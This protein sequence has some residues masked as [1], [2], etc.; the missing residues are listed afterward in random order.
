MS[1]KIS[2][3]LRLQ[4]R[5]EYKSKPVTLNALAQKYQISL[6]SLGKI[7]KDLP[8]WNKSQ[9][10]SPNLIENWFNC[11][12]EEAKAYY[13]GLFIT[14]GNIYVSTRN[15]INCNI[16]LQEQDK[17]LLDNWLR[18]IQSN[19]IPATDGRGCYQAVVHSNIMA[20]DLK[21]YGVVPN[22]TLITKLPN[23]IPKHLMPHLIRGIID[24]DGSIQAKWYVP[25]DGRKRFR[26]IITL[27]GT[28]QLV[29][30][31]GEFLNKELNITTPLNIY[32]YKNST[33]SEISYRNY[34]DIKKVGEYIYGSSSIY[35]KRKKEAYDLI[36]ERMTTM[37]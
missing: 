30:Q 5:K 34:E 22:K 2:N 8:K 14:D 20:M 1:K 29:Q 32:D 10:F 9:I 31:V 11:I 3:Q 12:D 35:M 27:C 13:L 21:K 7:L 33:L 23:N 19:R 18:L 36:I 17:Y 16:T 37:C 24:G 26:H 15:Q 4:I 6:P 25:K 28:H